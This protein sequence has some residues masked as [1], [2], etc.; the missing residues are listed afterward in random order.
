MPQMQFM[1]W[2]PEA[3][4]GVPEAISAAGTTLDAMF[5]AQEVKQ[6]QQQLQQQLEDLRLGRQKEAQ[7]AKEFD[8][9]QAEKALG[10][11]ADMADE[12]GNK[13]LAY[14][15]VKEAG[16]D[17]P[18][19]AALLEVPGFKERFIGEGDDNYGQVMTTVTDG[20]VKRFITT[21]ASILQAVNS[22]AKD[23]E[24]EDRS[25]I[26]TDLYKVLESP[27]LKRKWALADAIKIRSA[28]PGTYTEDQLTQADRTIEAEKQLT[29]TNIFMQGVKAERA[30]VDLVGAKLGVAAKEIKADEAHVEAVHKQY[31]NQGDILQRLYAERGVDQRAPTKER[32]ALGREA[33]EIQA[34]EM[35]LYN[36]WKQAQ[37]TR[38]RLGEKDPI[39]I[40][41][42]VI[43]FANAPIEGWEKIEN[44]VLLAIC[45]GILKANQG[46]LFKYLDTAHGFTAADRA[47]VA[48]ILTENGMTLEQIREIRG[49][50]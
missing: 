8:A 35:K 6:K 40:T 21:R 11:V 25:R 46:I 13:E 4:T 32:E 28:E 49:I 7:R 45:V 24:P 22:L 33:G 2:Q 12:T 41:G 14:A 17:I 9:S 1:G 43:D 27:D 34:F 42:A 10:A 16:K 36:G 50:D 47:L 48:T 23:M 29:A 31:A 15:V 37:L 20:I 19:I 26:T 39:A 5:K 3:S 38:N 44:P 30:E 18:T